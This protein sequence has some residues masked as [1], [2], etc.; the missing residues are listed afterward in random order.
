M[1]AFNDTVM[2]PS[3]TA[4]CKDDIKEVNNLLNLHEEKKTVGI[5]GARVPVPGRIQQGK[6]GTCYIVCL[7]NSV[8]NSGRKMFKIIDVVEGNLVK[9]VTMKGDIHTVR[10]QN[11][12]VMD[13]G[14]ETKGAVFSEGGFHNEVF[15]AERIFLRANPSGVKGGYYCNASRFFFDCCCVSFRGEE[16]LK[17]PIGILKR[18]IATASV[19]SRT[20]KMYPFHGY[21]VIHCDTD[22]IWLRDPTGFSPITTDCME[23]GLFWETWENAIRA[24]LVVTITIMR[25]DCSEAPS[26]G[27]NL[28][29]NFSKMTCKENQM[30]IAP[31]YCAVVNN[32]VPSNQCMYI[33]LSKEVEAAQPVR[34]RG[35]EMDEI[36]S[37]LERQQRVFNDEPQDPECA[38]CGPLWVTDKYPECFASGESRKTKFMSCLS[39]AYD[40]IGLPIDSPASLKLSEESGLKLP[41]Q[42]RKGRD[43]SLWLGVGCNP[44]DIFSDTMT[45]HLF[46]LWK[47]DRGWFITSLD[48]Q[49]MEIDYKISDL[50][51]LTDCRKV[52]LAEGRIRPEYPTIMSES[53]LGVFIYSHSFPVEFSHCP[54]INIDDS[55]KEHCKNNLDGMQT[56][57]I[58]FAAGRNVSDQ[59]WANVGKSRCIFWSST[60]HEHLRLFMNHIK[61]SMNCDM[62]TMQW[63]EFLTASSPAVVRLEKLAS[64]GGITVPT[65]PRLSGGRC[66]PIIPFDDMF[67]ITVGWEEGDIDLGKNRGLPHPDHMNEGDRQAAYHIILACVNRWIRDHKLDI[68]RKLKDSI[69]QPE[70]MNKITGE[71]NL[72]NVPVSQLLVHTRFKS[73]ANDCRFLKL[74]MSPVSAKWEDFFFFCE[75]LGKNFPKVS[76]DFLTTV[77]GNPELLRLIVDRQNEYLNK[78]GLRWNIGNGFIELATHGQPSESSGP[79]LTAALVFQSSVQREL[80][81]TPEVRSFG[82][83][84]MQ[85]YWQLSSK[86]FKPPECRSD[87]YRL[88]LSRMNNDYPE[89]PPGPS[90]VIVPN[91]MAH[92]MMMNGYSVKSSGPMDTVVELSVIPERS[93]N[94]I[95]YGDTVFV[96][97][98]CNCV[99][100]HHYRLKEF[101]LKKCSV[102][103]E[104]KEN[105][106]LTRCGC[107]TCCECIILMWRAD[108]RNPKCQACEMVIPDSD[109]MGRRDR[110][111]FIHRKQRVGC[112]ESR[113]CYNYFLDGKGCSDKSELCERISDDIF[114]GPKS[115][116]VKD[117]L[118]SLLPICSQTRV[119]VHASSVLRDF[120][121]EPLEDVLPAYFLI[122]DLMMVS[123]SD[124]D[125][126][127]MLKE[128]FLARNEKLIVSLCDSI[129]RHGV[130]FFTHAVRLGRMSIPLT[131]E[132]IFFAW[133]SGDDEIRDG[134]I[135]TINKFL[136]AVCNSNTSGEFRIALNHELELQPSNVDSIGYLFDEIHDICFRCFNQDVAVS[137]CRSIG[138]PQRNPLYRVDRRGDEVLVEAF[139]NK[140][141]DLS[142]I[143]IILGNDDS[144]YM[145]ILRTKKAPAGFRSSPIRNVELL[146]LETIPVEDLTVVSKAE[147][148]LHKNFPLAA[149]SISHRLTSMTG[150]TG[151]TVKLTIV[152]PAKSKSWT[153]IG[154]QEIKMAGDGSCFYKGVAYILNIKEHELRDN[155]YRNRDVRG[156]SETVRKMC[157]QAKNRSTWGGMVLLPVICSMYDVRIR[158]AYWDNPRI[159]EHYP[160]AKPTANICRDMLVTTTGGGHF[161]CL[162]KDVSTPDVEKYLTKKRIRILP[163]DGMMDKAVGSSAPEIDIGA[164]QPSYDL[165]F[166]PM[167]QS[168]RFEPGS[169]LVYLRQ[170]LMKHPSIPNCFHRPWAIVDGSYEKGL[171]L[172]MEVLDLATG[173]IMNYKTFTAASAGIPKHTILFCW[174]G[175]NE[176]P[177][178]KDYD[179]IDISYVM[180]S[181]W[182]GYRMSNHNPDPGKDVIQIRS[183]LS[184]YSRQIFAH[185]IGECWPVCRLNCRARTPVDGDRIRS[186]ANIRYY[187][188]PDDIRLNMVYDIHDNAVTWCLTY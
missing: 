80:M 72:S 38:K 111:F 55:S 146:G 120:E 108:T 66:D 121:D 168:P 157:S 14:S 145:N 127:I 115:V 114:T 142:L 106:S 129:S 155:L 69:N 98:S 89:I 33:G 27:F 100:I 141:P 18:P 44:N 93:D 84:G 60:S 16:I 47:D 153:E 50:K 73:Q 67:V 13:S 140:E 179:F 17:S 163:K 87:T 45:T 102:C 83:I 5:I 92:S 82:K 122:D 133:A 166:P 160:M 31:G 70:L 149:T 169:S 57:W 131:W 125:H 104:E 37:I 128:I 152:C 63:D 96:L 118:M 132:I 184:R 135:S 7:V 101:P 51:F 74:M 54:V 64:A 15:L 117:V 110:Y 4:F 77:Q 78:E 85:G 8:L 138:K 76:D 156:L 29:C 6:F 159:T 107:I 62:P 49:C 12:G 65:I 95:P 20:E 137:I 39:W 40:W 186:N 68:I 167:H 126:V 164:A 48:A 25:E 134:V 99:P 46:S 136:V 42:D 177:L 180:E 148:Y 52:A 24:G 144:S 182:I 11:Y 183:L 3:N 91:R 147:H 61:D 19:K 86:Q 158:V 178:L 123:M 26:P 174:Q 116:V 170:S 23:E 181:A 188:K 130:E 151:G 187:G 79:I 88:D 175:T 32:P 161:D 124:Q 43:C 34:I 172:N 162:R 36:D 119:S 22:R 81:V 154:Y 41:F 53:K 109:Y 30:Y 103:G 105:M 21:C 171:L 143:C 90:P 2:A 9:V 165:V 71:V 112:K 35:Y 28:A 10:L 75:K 185:M 1:M 176:L 58:P 113:L 139:S 97:R 56:K 59:V 150:K 94:E 173:E